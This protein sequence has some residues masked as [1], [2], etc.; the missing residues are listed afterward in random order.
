MQ[1]NGLRTDLLPPLSGL[2]S[3]LGN[4]DGTSGQ[5]P[6]DKLVVLI[7]SRLGP[8]HET[9]AE[10]EVD[11]AWPEGAVATVWGDANDA[12]NGVYKKTGL[13]AE[14]TWERQGDLPLSSISIA[15]LEQKAGVLALQN[16]QQQLDAVIGGLSP[17]GAWNAGSG[18]F[19]AGAVVNTFYIVDGAGTVDGQTF[20]VGDWLI[21]LIATPSTTI[22]ADNWV[23]A[24][25]STIVAA[26]AD[27]NLPE[28][29]PRRF[30]TFNDFLNTT[31]TP[32]WVYFGGGGPGGLGQGPGVRLLTQSPVLADTLGVIELDT[33][34]G[35]TGRAGM[36]GPAAILAFLYGPSRFRCRIRIPKLSD[37]TV[38]FTVRAGFAGLSTGDPLH[39]AFFRYTH[40]VNGGR[41]QAV[42]RRNNAETVA[43]TGVTIDRFQ[44]YNLEV[45][46]SA[47]LAEATYY[48][49]G[50]LVATITSN[51]PS[52][53]TDRVNYGCQINKS[54]GTSG[55]SDRQLWLDYALV[56]QIFS[57][58]T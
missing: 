52:L 4:Q 46:I 21:P 5:M 3:V 35:A 18:A 34:D 51:I 48:T 38:N 20:A 9:L 19:P 24:N 56:E 1:Q 2:D 23:R 41:F 49:D 7:S 40:S 36:I 42:A 39:G 22:Y 14:G 15:F 37:D 53:A 26:A 54:T 45:R 28:A 55:T 30:Y 8:S 43:D 13:A 29:S 11:L 17:A 47:D 44:L 10:L 50:V 16:L 31:G 27:V 57:V 12:N 33:G 6:M 32:E 25:Y 58:R